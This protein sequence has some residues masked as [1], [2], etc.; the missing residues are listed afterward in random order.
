MPMTDDTDDSGGVILDGPFDPDAQATV[1]DFIDY[2]EYLPADLIRSLTL[3]RGLDDRYLDSAQAVHQ[4]TQVYGQLPDLPSDKRPGAI[5]L[6]KDISSQVDRAINARESAYAEACRLYDVVDRHFDRLGCI[7]QKLEALPK[8]ASEEPSPPPEPTRKRARGGNKTNKDATTRITLRLDNN[9]NRR[10]KNRR[11]VLGADGTFDPDSP[12]ASTEQSDLE[13]DPIKS[14][15]KPAR[16]PKKE[17]ARRLSL[18]NGQS[19]A[20]ALAQLKPPPADAKL[21]SDDLPWLRLTE[22]EMT[23]L[24]KK[25]KKN[26]V[27]QPSEVMIHRELALANRGWEAYRAAKA[28]AEET[29]AEFIDCDNIEETRRGEAAKDLEE[30]KLSNRGMKLNEAKKLKREQLAREQALMEGEG[31]V[32][33]R[34]LPSPAQ[35]PPVANRSSRKRKREEANAEATE[36]VA[37]EPEMPVAAPVAAPAPV[38]VGPS[39]AGPSRRRSSRGAVPATETNNDLILPIKT[40][41]SPAVEAKLSP[42]LPS[43]TGS[44]SNRSLVQHVTTPT[45]P[46]TRPSS[47]RSAAA[48]SI[49]GGALSSI[50]TAIAASGRDRRIKSTTP[51]HK[52]PIRESSHAPSVPGPTR[53]RKRPA[54]GPISTGQDGGA[55]VSY[56]RRKAKP[57]KKRLSIRDSQD[58]RVDEDGVLEQID[59]N[60]PRYCLCG[61]VSFGTMICCENQDCDREWFH[62][63]CVGLTEVPSRTAKWYCP[64]CRVKLHKG[65]DGIIKGG[66]RR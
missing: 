48:A 5:A 7:R 59:A 64:Q 9:R 13:S 36:L 54:P 31:G 58:V 40:H 29:G 16:P 42:P 38:P 32:L 45:P 2:T 33:L 12:L 41:M 46:V 1:T 51:A 17:K 30:T 44:G 52:T 63:D 14:A 49:E 21:G 53:R 43:P 3:I 56:G 28:L 39:R 57:G 37:P 23:R 11:R 47:R 34:P 6:R 24:R 60:E 4:L 27:W 18:G 25:M 26:A 10:D 61:D 35:A 66:S 50:P 15:P 22:W 19:T 55:A 8:P 20:Q 65:E 62:L